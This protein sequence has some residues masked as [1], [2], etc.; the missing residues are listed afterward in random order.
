MPDPF[1]QTQE[2]FFSRKIKKLPHLS[3]VFGSNVLQASFQK[4]VAVTLD[5]KLT[6]YEPP[7]RR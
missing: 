2:V 6:F 4:H 3:L 7:S 5:V 1:K